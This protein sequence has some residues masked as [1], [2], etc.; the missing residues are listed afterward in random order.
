MTGHVSWR[1]GKPDFA[2]LIF[3]NYKDKLLNLCK[4]LQG[5]GYAVFGKV[6]EGMDVVDSMADAP[7]GS[8]WGI[9]FPQ[10]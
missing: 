2:S 9:R 7:T 8:L 6:V 4:A 3:V 1:V 5:W 10:N